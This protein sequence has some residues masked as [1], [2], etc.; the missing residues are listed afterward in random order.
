VT[1]CTEMSLDIVVEGI[2]GFDA[3]LDRTYDG[4]GDR[5]SHIS[6][7]FVPA[8]LIFV[9]GI[10]LVVATVIVNVFLVVVVFVVDRLGWL[11]R[12]G[13]NNVWNTACF[14]S[15]NVLA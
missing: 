13:A 14:R 6:A 12:R 7:I 5:R 3:W 4:G 11:G 1:Q 15:W 2:L 8:F 9:F 10:F